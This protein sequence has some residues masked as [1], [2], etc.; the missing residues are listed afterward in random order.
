MYPQDDRKFLEEEI[1][2][3]QIDCRVDENEAVISPRIGFL[4]GSCS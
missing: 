3:F 2:K 4:D 1:D